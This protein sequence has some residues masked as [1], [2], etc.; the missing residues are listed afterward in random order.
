MVDK[1]RV[2]GKADK[3]KGAVKEQVGKLTG[4][5][6]TEARGKAEKNEGKARDTVGK[7]KDKVR[8]TLKD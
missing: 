2:K 7:G 3:V 4:D 8:N 5:E 1:E 6:E